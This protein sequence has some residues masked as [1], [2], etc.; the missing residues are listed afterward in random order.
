MVANEHLMG[1]NDTW[2][3]PEK[4]WGPLVEHLGPITL[5]PMT[6]PKSKVPAIHRWT[7]WQGNV[8]RYGFERRD[9][10]TA[11]WDHYTNVFCNGPW[12]DLAWWCEKAALREGPDTTLLVPVRTTGSA[13][14]EWIFPYFNVLYLNFRVQFDGAKDPLPG[15]CALCYRGT[16]L[17]LFLKAFKGKGTLM[18]ESRKV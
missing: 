18:S 14:Q 3:T 16:A 4:I 15:H 6:N 13:W 12:S 17:D 10:R 5:D 7:D 1:T 11:S 8:E 9:A 2:C